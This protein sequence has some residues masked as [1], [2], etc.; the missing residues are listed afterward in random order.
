MCCMLVCTCHDI[1]VCRCIHVQVQLSY[2]LDR[3][4]GWDAVQVSNT[5]SYVCSVLRICKLDW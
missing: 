5:N 1:D 2:L 4:D 3:E